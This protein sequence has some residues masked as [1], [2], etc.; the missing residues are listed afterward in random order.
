[1]HSVSG[2]SRSSSSSS[3]DSDHDVERAQLLPE[4]DEKADLDIEVS[5]IESPP[6]RRSFQFLIWTAINTLATIG[7]VSHA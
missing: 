6:K 2:E 4:F 3:S 5:E 7:I 1:M